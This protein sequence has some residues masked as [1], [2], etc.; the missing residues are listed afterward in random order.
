MGK[1]NASTFQ[2]R[3]KPA[4]VLLAAFVFA[5]AL[6]G[7]GKASE[8]TALNGAES[9]STIQT[10]AVSAQMMGSAEEQVAEV[11]ASLEMDIVVKASGDVTEKLRTKG[12]TV[13]QGE[14]LFRIDNADILSEKRRTEISLNNL[15]E[16]LAKTRIDST[17]SKL[18]LSNAVLRSRTQLQR[19]REEY[20]KLRNDYDAGLVT[21]RQVDQAAEMLE[22]AQRDL[23]LAEKQLAA[24]D[25]TNPLASLES[26]IATARVSL[27]DLNRRLEYYA[28]KAP[29]DGV[30][31]DLSV[32]AGMMVSQGIRVGQILRMDPVVIKAAIPEALLKKVEGK[33][34]L[35]FYLPSDPERRYEGKVTFVGQS[36]NEQTKSYALEIEASNP[37]K[38][39][40]PGMRVQVVLSDEAEQKALAVPSAAISREGSDTFVYVIKEG[41]VEKRVITVGRVKDQYQEVTAGLQEGEQVVTRGQARL[42]DGQSIEEQSVKV[43]QSVKTGQVNGAG[44]EKTQ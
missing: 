1:S 14:V 34:S 23:E 28:V 2:I 40:K 25:Q 44:E 37:D 10:E 19:Q 31:A 18:Q 6:A 9:K 42:K 33:E 38:Q 32:E 20:N 36:V 24:L 27:A 22:H 12:D 26:Q 30:L 29:T 7:C 11:A 3:R 5:A 43:D 17:N 41:K 39:L 13:K 35:A 8:T 4:A 15:Q 21:Q 16:T